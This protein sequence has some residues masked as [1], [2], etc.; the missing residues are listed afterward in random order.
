[1]FGF[2]GKGLAFLFFVCLLF[3]FVFALVPN[4]GHGLAQLEQASCPGGQFLTLVGGTA[5][6]ACAAAGTGS[7]QWSGTNP[8]PIYYT[9]GN[10]GIGTNAPGNYRLNVNGSIYA[11]GVIYAAYDAKIYN[12]IRFTDS[13]LGTTKG[14]IHVG[15]DSTPND[16]YL[17]GGNADHMIITSSG[18]IGIGT[19]TG[20][21]EKLV[22]AGNIEITGTGNGLIFPNGTKQTTAAAGGGGITQITSTGGTISSSI[23]GGTANLEVASD[24]ITSSHIQANAVNASEIANGAVGSMKIASS[25][26]TE[27]KINT[28]AVTTDKI[29]SSAVTSAKIA[30]NAVT[31]TKINNGAVTSNKLAANSVDTSKIADGAV[32]TSKLNWA[33][34]AGN[35]D[36]DGTYPLGN[37]FI[38]FLTQVD[39]S[40]RCDIDGFVGGNWQI[41]V[42]GG[43][44]CGVGCVN[45][46]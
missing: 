10:V 27:S 32:T 8:G 1:M 20:V 5:G 38:C 6:F 11:T 45:S 40:G 17:G 39:G 21:T 9:G 7:S 31:E 46:N 12:T 25:A 13:T 3:G 44:T 14:I 41:E 15:T 35:F 33:T 18:N 36:A 43:N 23:T 26:V 16:L 42:Y 2:F 24:S 29:A 4:P 37:F 34:T 19:T 28:G 30:S 22:V